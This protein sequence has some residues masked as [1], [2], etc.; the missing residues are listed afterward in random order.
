MQELCGINF[1]HNI[2][3]EFM[4]RN[5]KYFLIKQSLIAQCNLGLYL[6][7]FHLHHLRSVNGYLPVNRN[8]ILV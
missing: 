6:P 5:N 7:A 8:V 1:E 2:N 3:T 4:P